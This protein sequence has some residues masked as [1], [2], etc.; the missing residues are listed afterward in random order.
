M[1]PDITGIYEDAGEYSGERYYKLT[2][3]EWYLFWDGGDN[4]RIDAVLGDAEPPTWSRTDLDIEGEYTPVAP[5]DGTATVT[6]I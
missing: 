3:Q 4:W 5:A 1:D 6:E 2:D